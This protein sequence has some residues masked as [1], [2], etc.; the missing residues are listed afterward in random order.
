[1]RYAWAG[2]AL[3]LLAACGP[4]QVNER[5]IADADSEPGNWLTHG[6]TYNEDR[7]SPLD[8]INTQNV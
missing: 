3:A 5:R 1:M 6:R 7:Y 8:A 2:L 4:A